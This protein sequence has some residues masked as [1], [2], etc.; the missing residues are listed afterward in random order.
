MVGNSDDELGTEK[1]NLNQ[2][3][4]PK[5]LSPRATH[6][7]YMIKFYVTLTSLNHPPV[8]WTQ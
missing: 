5:D 7:T 4:E 6:Y 3:Y 1:V 2:P 8:I